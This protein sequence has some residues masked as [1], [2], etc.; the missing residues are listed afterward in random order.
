MIIR[1]FAWLRDH[2]GVAHE[3]RACPADVHTVAE[4]M[5]HLCDNAPGYQTAFAN[6]DVIKVAINQEFASADAPV[7][8]GDE[9]AFF[10]P[11]TGG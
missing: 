10:P 1:Y 3:T 9:I 6:R 4:L 8:E 5:D 11:V 7:K 2:T